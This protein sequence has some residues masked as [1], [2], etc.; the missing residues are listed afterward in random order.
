[1]KTDYFVGT[2]FVALCVL[3]WGIPI[4]T[5]FNWALD[6]SIYA[7]QRAGLPLYLMFKYP[8]ERGWKYL[9]AVC[10]LGVSSGISDAYCY[11]KYDNLILFLKVV[12]TIM[13]FFCFIRGLNAKNNN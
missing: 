8:K 5:E 6:L 2:V 13:A 9:S 10:L 7:V 4:S 12:L 1:M 3:T 11:D